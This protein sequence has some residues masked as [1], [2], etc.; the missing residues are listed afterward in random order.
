ML[1][2]MDTMKKFYQ[3]NV[4]PMSPL[5]SEF[6]RQSKQIEHPASEQV[7]RNL[8]T[9][10]ALIDYITEYF[11]RPNVALLLLIVSIIS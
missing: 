11:L 3:R 8:T 1:M 2:V 10:A 7:H 5:L 4:F 9:E 6:I